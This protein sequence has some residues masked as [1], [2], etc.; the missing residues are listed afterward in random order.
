MLAALRMKG[1]YFGFKVRAACPTIYAP[2]EGHGGIPKRIEAWRKHHVGNNCGIQ[3]ILH[4]W[5]LAN[6]DDLNDFV[7]GLKVANWRGGVLLLDTLSAAFPG[8]K[9][10]DSDGMGFVIAAAKHIAAELACLVIIVHHTGKDEG[11]GARGWSG[12]KGAVDVELECRKVPIERGDKYD[13]ELE[14]VKVKDGEDGRVIPFR[15]L[16]V[17][18]GFDGD[19]DPRSSLVVVPPETKRPDV[20]FGGDLARPAVDVERDK[21]D[22]TFV[23]GWAKAKMLEGAH[24]SLKSLENDLAAMKTA[25]SNLTQARIRGAVHRLK[26]ADRLQTMPASESPTNNSWLRAVDVGAPT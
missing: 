7:D 10:N 23:W 24:P 22:D 2:F 4:Q 18:L 3:F 16:P 25:R 12:L 17:D 11:R 15:V 6:A 9:E 19:G 5:N 13:R 14:L 26:G 20:Q 1:T 21:D 8:I